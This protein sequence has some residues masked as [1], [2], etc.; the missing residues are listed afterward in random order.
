VT[1]AYRIVDWKRRYEIKADKR[2]ANEDTPAEKLRKRP[3]DF[4]KWKVF[5]HRLGHK[6]RMMVQ[7]AWKPGEINELAVLGFFGKLLELAG[8]QEDQKHRGWILDEDQQPMT[9]QQIAELLDIQEV[10][11]L[12]GA[13]G[14]LIDL[15]WIEKCQFPF[16]IN[17]VSC[18]IRDNLLPLQKLQGAAKIAT[19]A[20]NPFL[21]ETETEDKRNITE[22][23]A[24][25]AA[26]DFSDSAD[27]QINGV[28]KT[29]HDFSPKELDR[30]FNLFTKEAKEAREDAVKQICRLLRLNPDNPSDITTFRDIFDQL[31]EGIIAGRLTTEIFSYAVDEARDAASHRFGRLGRFVNAM[32]QEPF[33][34]V[35]ERRKIPDSK[36]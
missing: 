29:I 8:D 21:N 24:S 1:Q 7:K 26:L 6:Y 15:N 12:T 31:E 35:P 14:I 5:G 30:K 28:L 4:I 18:E 20:C 19:K 22:E 16:S 27:A 17:Q 9:I 10:G 36:Y 3:H 33:G 34:Y 11:R 32:K 23:K 25:D 2:D 13:M